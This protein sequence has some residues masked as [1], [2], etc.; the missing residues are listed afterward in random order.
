MADGEA[1]D[2]MS[3]K[4]LRAHISAAGLSFAGLL[5]TQGVRSR[6]SLLLN[7]P[8]YASWA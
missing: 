4:E 8:G 6:G 5:L 2:A 3:V 1:I 7:P